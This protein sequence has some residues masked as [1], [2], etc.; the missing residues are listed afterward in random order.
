MI[1]VNETAMSVGQGSETTIDHIDASSTCIPSTG[2][3]SACI[4]CILA[5]RLNDKKVSPFIIPKGI[6]KK[7]LNVFQE[8]IFSKPKKLGKH[9][10]L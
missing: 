10:R 1:A 2:Y 3:E 4:T 9:K 8:Y 7:R 6:K 5:I